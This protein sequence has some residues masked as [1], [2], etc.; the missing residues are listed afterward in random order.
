MKLKT[1]ETDL[2]V[3]WCMEA[4]YPFASAEN[5]RQHW[6]YCVLFLLTGSK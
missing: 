4:F 3:D 5:Q 6:W 2:G 1:H